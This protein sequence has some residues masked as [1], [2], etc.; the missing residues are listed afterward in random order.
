MFIVCILSDLYWFCDSGDAE[1]KMMYWVTEEVTLNSGGEVKDPKNKDNLSW[2]YLLRAHVRK[3]FGFPAHVVTKPYGVLQQHNL[4]QTTD[5]PAIE[6]RTVANIT[7][8]R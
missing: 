2:V 3:G 7:K 1:F 4:G 6:N 8:I 5:I